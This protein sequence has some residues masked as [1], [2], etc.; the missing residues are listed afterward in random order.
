M[1][2]CYRRDRKL[3]QLMHAECSGQSM[4]S[5]KSF[6]KVAYY[7]NNFSPPDSRLDS[8]VVAVKKFKTTSLHKSP[9][10]ME[11]AFMWRGQIINKEVNQH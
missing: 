9:L 4:A 5:G 1:V 11:L 6:T 7:C 2:I 8:G 10:I 3:V